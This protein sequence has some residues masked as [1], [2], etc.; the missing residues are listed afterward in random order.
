MTIESDAPHA[1]L[2]PGLA[3]YQARFVSSGIATRMR[4]DV[5]QGWLAITGVLLTRR[6]RTFVQI[7]LFVI[8]FV[9]AVA[10]IVVRPLWSPQLFA[11][12]AAAL[13]AFLVIVL[14]AG[15]P[16]RVVTLLAPLSEVSCVAPESTVESLGGKTKTVILRGPFG[17]EWSTNGMIKLTFTSEAD[18]LG[19]VAAVRSGI[20]QYSTPPMR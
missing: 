19:L 18:A 8:V 12:V 6:W 20:A 4:V 5:H 17:G 13:F 1:L 10:V 9:I 3:S 14:T 16:S 2:G 7:A 15:R 11:V